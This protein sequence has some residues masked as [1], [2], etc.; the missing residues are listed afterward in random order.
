MK[1]VWSVL[2]YEI[3]A[4]SNKVYQSVFEVRPFPKAKVVFA[5]ENHTATVKPR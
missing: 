2:N 5:L 4:I 1:R 3:R